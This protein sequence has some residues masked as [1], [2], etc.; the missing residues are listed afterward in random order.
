MREVAILGA[1]ELG[2][3]TAH[4]I[5]RRNAARTVRLID[6]AGRI[7][8]GKALDLNQAAASE[9]FA[10]IVTGSTDLASAAGADV[11]VIADRSGGVEWSGEEGLTLVRRIR[12]LAPRAAVVAAGAGHCELVDRCVRELRVPRT[13]IVGSGGEAYASAATAIVALELDVSPRDVA[14]AI[15]GI[16]P[17]HVV[18]GWEHATV[19]GF[20][21]T[22]RLGEPIRR[23]LTLKIRALWPV[24]PHTLASAACK[25][26]EM[27]AGRSRRSVTT[28]VGPD[29]LSGSRHRAAALP[30]QI[31]RD[32]NIEVVAPPLSAMEQVALDNA[33]LL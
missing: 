3:L 26:V 23:Q 15:L 20:A 12:S 28:F 19:A 11:I 14:I 1:G 6:D 27:L 32:G 2:G 16:P 33:M 7:A 21:I 8:E 4:I 31:D 9:R 10:T 24:G 18:V 22:A 5:A 17:R 30:I 25:V 13:Q 29:D